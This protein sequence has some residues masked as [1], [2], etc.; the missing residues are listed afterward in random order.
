M[1]EWHTP[2]SA[3]AQ[4]KNAP[5]G[6]LLASLLEAAKEQCIEF[7]PAVTPPAAGE[8]ENIPNRYRLAQLLQAQALW[9]AQ[10]G[11]GPDDMFGGGDAGG[12]RVYDMGQPIRRLLRPA[13]GLPGIG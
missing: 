1:A 11:P 10:Q 9:T 3:A 12:V 5:E 2:Q 6:D 4:W 8:P 13:R 7:A